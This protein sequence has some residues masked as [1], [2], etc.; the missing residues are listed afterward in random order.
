MILEELCDFWPKTK[1]NILFSPLRE[2]IF[3]F[4]C[5]LDPIFEYSVN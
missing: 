2:D 3:S 5:P 4:D 1:N